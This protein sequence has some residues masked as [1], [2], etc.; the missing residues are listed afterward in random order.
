MNANRRLRL[1]VIPAALAALTLAGCQDEAPTAAPP[2][3]ATS[4]AAAAPTEAP[5]TEAPA[6]APS[7]TEAPAPTTQAPAPAPSTSAAA[8]GVVCDSS[9]STAI[10]RAGMAVKPLGTQT[11]TGL[12]YDKDGSIDITVSKPTIDSSST[13]SYFPGDGMVAITFPVTIKHK[14]G[15][16]YIPSPQ[17][18]GLV[19]D[20]DNVCDRDYGTIT[21][22]S[23]QIQIESLKNGASASG[24][25]TFAVP[26]GADYKKYAV[27]WKDEGGG[28]AQLA[29]AAS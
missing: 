6:P 16:Y 27:V 26:A 20:Q 9:S 4:S 5:T 21:P 12:G 3:P 15:D 19:D 8:S 2:A 11:A 13:D 28:K 17:Q 1:A 29:W 25:V 18:F 24:L 22:R 10:L 14:T 7:T 23:K